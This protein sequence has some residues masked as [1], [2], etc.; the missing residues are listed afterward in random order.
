[1]RYCSVALLFTVL[2]LSRCNTATIRDKNCNIIRVERCVDFHR[3]MDGTKQKNNCL[4][5]SMEDIL[6]LPRTKCEV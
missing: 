5:H 2:F 3:A 1:M 6:N 4:F